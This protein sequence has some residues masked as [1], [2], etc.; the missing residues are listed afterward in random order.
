LKREFFV[1][2]CPSSFQQQKTQTKTRKNKLRRRRRRQNCVR[3]S[4]YIIIIIINIIINIIIK[5]KYR[6]ETSLFLSSHDS[7]AYKRR[8][9]DGFQTVIKSNFHIFDSNPH[10]KRKVHHVERCHRRRLTSL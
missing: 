1:L 4:L 7:H 3:S 2:L 5:Y 8:T 9:K 10:S 6:G